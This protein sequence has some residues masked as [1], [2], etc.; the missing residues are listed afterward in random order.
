VPLIE[1]EPGTAVV[2]GKV[3]L[4]FGVVLFTVTVTELG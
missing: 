4:M 3:I 2:V 1:S